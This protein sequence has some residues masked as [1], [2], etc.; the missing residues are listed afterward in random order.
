MWHGV[1]YGLGKGR[2][3]ASSGRLEYQQPCA[4]LHCAPDFVGA[5]GSVSKDRIF[6]F[7][8]ATARS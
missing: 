2:S 7:Y 1:L 5:H 6:I 3:A 4:D 8:P